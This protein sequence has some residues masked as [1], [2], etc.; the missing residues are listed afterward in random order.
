MTDEP[1]FSRTAEL[2]ENKSGRIMKM[3]VAVNAIPARK[4]SA[5]ML[6]RTPFGIT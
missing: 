2:A 4:K 6:L 3:S 1:G 5:Q